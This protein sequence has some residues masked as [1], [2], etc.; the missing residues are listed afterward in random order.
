M[1]SGADIVALPA[2][3]IRTLIAEVA[4]GAENRCAGGPPV[5]Q[6]AFLQPGAVTEID[7]PPG[8]GAVNLKRA[9]VEV[10]MPP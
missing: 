7:R 5:A 1:A 4:E 6:E 9:Q 3:P 10:A 8:L 2:V